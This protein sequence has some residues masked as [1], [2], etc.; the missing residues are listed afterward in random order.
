M[1]FKSALSG[2]HISFFFLHLRTA[3]MLH[4]LMLLVF[5][6]RVKVLLTLSQPQRE[7]KAT[8]LVNGL[9]Y[10]SLLFVLKIILSHFCL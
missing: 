4:Q 10:P 9:K 1:A 6:W 8:R 2:V 5:K 3:K 7:K